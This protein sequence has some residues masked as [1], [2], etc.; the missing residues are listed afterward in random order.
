MRAASGSKTIAIAKGVDRVDCPVFLLNPPA[1]VIH[2]LED[3]A[4]VQQVE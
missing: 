2:G 3:I 4:L 1:A